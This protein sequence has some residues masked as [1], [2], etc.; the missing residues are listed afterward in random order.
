MSAKSQAALDIM[1][2]SMK[3]HPNLT[4]SSKRD[5]NEDPLLKEIDPKS[6]CY[7]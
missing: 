1:K 4:A 5:P 7:A 6:K 3:T 2:H